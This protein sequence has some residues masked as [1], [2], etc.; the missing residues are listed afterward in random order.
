MQKLFQGCQLQAGAEYLHS[1]FQLLQRGQAGGDAD[2][3]VVRVDAVG[4]SSAGS[5]HGNA[6]F[7]AKSQSALGRTG[8]GVQADK[9]AALGPLPLSK[10]QRVDL[11]FQGV[12]NQSKFGGHHAGMALHDLNGM[13]LVL[14][15]AHMAQ[16]IDLVVR[17][18]LHTKHPGKVADVANAGGHNGNTAAGKG[19]LGGGGELKHHIRVAGLFAKAQNIRERNILTFKFMQAVGIVPHNDKI[20]SGRL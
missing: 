5:G 1:L 19:D 20:G 13:G 3:A 18:H 7:L 6:R 12:G 11:S 2:I 15:V 8:H 9:V 17:D 10:A 4:V 16:L 14:Q